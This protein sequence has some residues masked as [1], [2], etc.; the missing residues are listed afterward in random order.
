MFLV[1]FSPS[2]LDSIADTSLLPVEGI[3]ATL[4]QCP[5]YQIDKNHTNCGLRTRI[6]PIVDFIQ[7]LLS[8]NSVPVARLAW[9]NSRQATSWLPMEF[10]KSEEE[11]PGPFRFTRAIAGDQRLRFE[12]ALGAERFARDVFTASSWDWSAEEEGPESF[13]RYNIF[14]NPNAKK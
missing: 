12:H 2:S 4:K 14:R 13:E 6:L 3:L 8:A 7:T 11:A 5:S 10:G 9:K 1:D